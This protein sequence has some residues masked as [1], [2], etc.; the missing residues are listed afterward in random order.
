MG[1][2]RRHRDFE[3]EHETDA[4][5]RWKQED[6]ERRRKEK[7]KNLDAPDPSDWRPEFD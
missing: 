7:R 5:D 4:H 1:K 2:D 3:E 6:R